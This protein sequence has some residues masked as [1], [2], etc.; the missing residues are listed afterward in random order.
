MISG[1]GHHIGPPIAHNQVSAV[2]RRESG[3]EELTGFAAAPGDRLARLAP[4]PGRVR[5]EL[6][7][8]HRRVGRPQRDGRSQPGG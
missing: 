5:A 1:A 7:I 2:E 4:D 8:E 6:R 3:L